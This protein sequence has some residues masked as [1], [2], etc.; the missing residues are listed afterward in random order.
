MQRCLPVLRSTQLTNTVSTRPYVF[1]HISGLWTADKMNLVA[2]PSE[3]IGQNQAAHNVAAADVKRSVGADHNVQDRIFSI[4]ANKPSA[5]SQSSGVSISCTSILGSI[6]AILC[7]ENIARPSQKAS[8][9][10]Q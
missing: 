5:V 8:Y 10:P 2:V 1:N 4:N 9:V 6:I 3:L 7:S